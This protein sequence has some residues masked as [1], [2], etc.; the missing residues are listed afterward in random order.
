MR[1]VPTNLHTFE[2]FKTERLS[3]PWVLQELI[4]TDMHG[5]AR[6]GAPLTGGDAEHEV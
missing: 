6:S 2:T 5:A 1:R 4:H 3:H